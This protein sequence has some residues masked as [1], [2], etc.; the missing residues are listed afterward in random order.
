M[1]IKTIIAI[2]VIT[3]AVGLVEY[4]GRKDTDS[5]AQF[6]DWNGYVR[7]MPSEKVETKRLPNSPYW[8]SIA[9]IDLSQYS[10]CYDIVEQ[11]ANFIGLDIPLAK[12]LIDTESAFRT[13]AINRNSNSYDSGLAQLNNKGEPV[14]YYMNKEMQLSDGSS[15]V[16]NWQNYKTNARL[17]VA[18]GLRRYQEY[19]KQ[20]NNNPFA[21]YAVYNCGGSVL[22]TV[23]NTTSAVGTITALR[24]INQQGAN[25]L[26]NNYCVKFKKWIGGM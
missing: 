6:K 26:K 22:S 12:T 3:G 14:L 11:E 13:N 8:V 10:N 18:M 19:L 4:A 17:N 20:C 2:I 24:K 1:N 23:K 25:N 9:D 16:V 7:S 5:Y 21:A 15:I